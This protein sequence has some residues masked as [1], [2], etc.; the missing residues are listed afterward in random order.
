MSAEAAMNGSAAVRPPAQ[1]QPVLVECLSV[2]RVFGS[3]PSAVPAVRDVTVAVH[4]GTR[5]ALTGPSGSGKSTL[6]HLMAGLEIPTG[7]TVRWPGLDG[8][9]HG[10]PGVVGMVF[11]GPSLI[12]ALNV[13]ENVALS[14]LLAGAAEDE[15]LRRAL[16]A[17]DRLG[18]GEL[19]RK[20]PEEI[21]GGQAQRVAVAR[22]LACRPSLILADEPTGQLDH[23]IGDRVMSVLLGAAKE[24]RAALVVCTHDPTVAGRL[25]ERWRMVDGRLTVPGDERAQESAAGRERP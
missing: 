23:D 14:L 2:S 24:L 18:I 4:A 9:P 1:C 12:P 25:T 16:V 22:V 8:P 13:V 7:G 3:G 10:R 6:L 19:E 17:L 20:L 21:S 5:V 11:Q 15:A